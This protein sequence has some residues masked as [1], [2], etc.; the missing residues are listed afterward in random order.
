MVGDGGVVR[1]SNS[2]A[3]DKESVVLPKKIFRFFITW[4]SLW[5]ANINK[6]YGKILASVLTALKSTS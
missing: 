3:S 6:L 1:S 4:T 2:N 5:I